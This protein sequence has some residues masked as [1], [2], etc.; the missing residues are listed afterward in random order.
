MESA[1]R[2]ERS[3]LQS[4]KNLH[5]SSHKWYMLLTY[6]FVGS[7]KGN[8]IHF[9]K[10]TCWIFPHTPNKK[11]LS[12][13]INLGICIYIFSICCQYNNTSWWLLGATYSLHLFSFMFKWLISENLAQRTK[14]MKG[15]TF[16]V[17]FS[18]ALLCIFLGAVY[19]EQRS[20]FSLLPHW[21]QYS[22]TWTPLTTDFCI[23]CIS[24]MVNVKTTR[25]P[26]EAKTFKYNNNGNTYCV[27]RL[28]LF[29]FIPLEQTQSSFM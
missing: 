17:S 3:K 11:T 8:H 5:N 24:D 22:P 27:Q 28:R 19:M 7:W 15:P 18:F 29:F 16:W 23:W 6:V 20:S 12:A 21:Y 25:E 4:C 26:S 10:L 13:K 9:L 14:T 1:G 2:G